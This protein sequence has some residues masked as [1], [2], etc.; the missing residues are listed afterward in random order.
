MLFMDWCK[1]NSSCRPPAQPPTPICGIITLKNIDLESPKM[2]RLW[3]CIQISRNC[4]KFSDHFESKNVP[5]G[6]LISDLFC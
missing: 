2:P 4:L 3:N 5:F 6:W 1:L